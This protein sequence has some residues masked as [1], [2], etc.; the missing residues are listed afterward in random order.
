M[1]KSDFVE[2]RKT[3][4]RLIYLVLAEHLTVREAILKYPKDVN[5]VTL[6]AV[7]HALVHREADEDLR[8]DTDYREEQ[9][10][11]LEFVAQT[12]QDGSPLPKNFIK[13]YEKYYSDISLPYSDN[14][15]E[16]IKRLCKFLN[17]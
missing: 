12:L 10:D 6:R 8:K 9:D 4:S 15:K 16:I 7:Y 13:N 2:P 5:D 11:Y 14:F 1:K 3:V 17:V